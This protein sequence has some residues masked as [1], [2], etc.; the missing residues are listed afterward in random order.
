MVFALLH[1]LVQRLGHAPPVAPKETQFGMHPA[2]YA[3]VF[4]ILS[5]TSLPLAAWLGTML[6]PVSDRTCALMMAFGAGALLFA[7]TVDSS[8]AALPVRSR[9]D[10]FSVRCCW[11]LFLCVHS[12]F[13]AS[14]HSYIGA[15]S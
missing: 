14:L 9:S 6:A 7:V 2:M 5:G 8:Q 1:D 4:G 13:V 3:L 11:F 10:K 12:I 15:R